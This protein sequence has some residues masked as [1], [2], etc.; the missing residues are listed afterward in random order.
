MAGFNSKR[1]MSNYK[2]ATLDPMSWQ[3]QLMDWER[4]ATTKYLIK[5]TGTASLDIISD[6]MDNM[7]ANYPGK[8][9]LEW[10]NTAPNEYHLV[11]KFKDPNHETLWKIQYGTS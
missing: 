8:Y 6:C 11:L 5:G 3:E 7:Q 4:G 2:N 1:S 10:A 9:R